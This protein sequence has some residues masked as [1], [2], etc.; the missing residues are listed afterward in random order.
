MGARHRRK[1]D[2]AADCR[3]QSRRANRTGL[4]WQILPAWA[5]GGI[6]AVPSQVELPTPGGAPPPV[7]TPRTASPEVLPASASPRQTIPRCPDTRKAPE[8][9]SLQGPC[10]KTLPPCLRLQQVTLLH[11]GPHRR[12]CCSSHKEEAGRQENRP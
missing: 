7:Y 11:P 5:P 12:L 1:V 8:A 4:W 2:A 6:P 10:V 3:P 9:P